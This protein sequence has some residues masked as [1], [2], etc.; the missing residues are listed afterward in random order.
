MKG[1]PMHRKLSRA[2]AVA[3]AIAVLAIAG[4]A[5]QATAAVSA[6]AVSALLATT[7][8]SGPDSG[9]F[10]IAPAP[11][12]DGSARGYFTMTIAAGGTARDM[13]VLTNDGTTT[14]QLKVSITN[15][16]TAANSGSAFENLSG[17]CTGAAC[18]VTGLPAAVT[19]PPHTRESLPFHVAV[20]ADAKPRQ[21]LAGIT[22]QPAARPKPV[23]AKSNG[24]AAAGVVIVTQITIGVAVTVGQLA[25]LHSKMAVTGISAIWVGTLVRLS[26]NVRNH[27][28]RF[29]KGTGSMS[30]E[31]GGARH[32]YPVTM[33]TV[34]PGDGAVLPANGTG[35]HAGAW[36]CTIRI[37]D[38]G[39][40]T[41]TWS[42]SVTVPST[43]PATPKRVANGDYILA[44]SNGGV[45][46]WAIALMVLGALILV[47]LWAIL[48]HRERNRRLNNPDRH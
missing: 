37:K 5:S 28:Q 44:T 1:L 41:D 10:S 22:A 20:P 34:L 15:G 29:T 35:M 46:A 12:P 43:V 14:R 18:W 38:S 23:S 24:H 42:G 31:L 17:K 48:I 9:Q 16:T 25:T 7:A 21:Y 2:A 19:L 11:A 30:C 13:I 40:S 33:G 32:T 8:A 39:G 27:G 3:A 47:S 36:Q 4:S 26:T 45:P 6:Q